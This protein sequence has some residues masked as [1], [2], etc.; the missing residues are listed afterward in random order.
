MNLSPSSTSLPFGFLI[1]TRAFPQAKDC[2]VLLNSL[3][4]VK[5]FKVQE[6]IEQNVNMK[7]F[8]Q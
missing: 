8:M 5:K 1:N 3:S 7:S 6:K 4:S 2:K